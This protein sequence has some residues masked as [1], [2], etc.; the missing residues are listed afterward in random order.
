MSFQKKAE[1]LVSRLKEQNMVEK[2]VK[3]SYYTKR[4]KDFFQ[5]SWL[6]VQIFSLS[7]NIACAIFY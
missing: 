3:V 1:L 5:K 7:V 2:D 6:V 4:S